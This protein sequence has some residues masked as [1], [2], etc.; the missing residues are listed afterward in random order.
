MRRH[1][2]VPILL[3][4]TLPLLPCQVPPGW[5]VVDSFRTQPPGPALGDGGL[6]LVHP[7]TPGVVVPITGLPASV[8]GCQ[9]PA[10]RRAGSQWVIMGSTND[11]V[12]TASTAFQS[13][14]PCVSNPPRPVELHILTLAGAQVVST[15]TYQLGTLL[16]Q[17]AV[18]TC[19]GALLPDGSIL[20]ALDD[21]GVA[22][23]PLAGAVLG[24]VDPGFSPNNQAAVTPV[25]V[26]W[27]PGQA[28]VPG[29]VVNALALSP[30]GTVAYLGIARGSCATGFLRS[31]VWSVPVPAGGQA[32]LLAVA[33][34]QDAISGL[35][36][37]LAG[38]LLATFVFG[39]SPYRLRKI[40]VSTG[41][42][43]PIPTAIGNLNGVAIEPA[44]GDYALVNDALN[45][46]PMVPAVYHHAVASGTTTLLAS[47][48]PPSYLQPCGFSVG[49][50]NLSGI[51]IAPNPKTL[52]PGTSGTNSS[53]QWQPNPNGLPVT[54]QPFTFSLVSST[55]CAAGLL[56]ISFAPLSSPLLLPGC[57]FL[58]IHIDPSP[59]QLFYLETLP[60]A[61]TITRT[62]LLPAGAG[63]SGLT[64]HFQ[65]VHADC[66]ASPG[67]SFTLL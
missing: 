46:N 38:D 4:V 6:F 16:P 47:G 24:R 17:S 35:A 39:Q 65:P 1:I 27:P 60:C 10:D 49:W 54:G 14:S 23:E 44:T 9:W 30:S 45:Q 18:G 22:G 34:T 36:A 28:L 2:V 12:I 48:P 66:G 67:L 37:D 11:T 21:V 62:W 25:S 59:G 53:Y 5:Y 52:G 40:D 58:Q 3:F 31:E 56:G 61:P 33:S 41:A 64:V 26:T 32:T 50:G 63:L 55:G 29:E 42:I 51:A 8:T 7:R 43:T 15:T 57:P 13:T 20:V 19:A